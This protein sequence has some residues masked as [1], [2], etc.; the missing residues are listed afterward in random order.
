M[1]QVQ[2]PLQMN[3]KKTAD[4]ESFIGNESVVK[5]LKEFGSLP[6]FTYIWGKQ[7]SGKSHLIDA[8]NDS[9]VAQSKN[10]LILDAKMLSHDELLNVIP[11]GVESILIDDVGLCASNDAGEVGLFN[12]FN[13]CKSLDCKLVVTARIPARADQWLLPDLKSRLNS[14]LILHLEPLNH[15]KALLCLEQQFNVHGIPLDPAVMNYLRANQNTSFEYL[16]EL[17]LCLAAE[18]L[19]LKRKVT[20]PLVKKAIQ[21]N[22]E[23]VC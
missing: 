17:F 9:L 18:S 11:A 19:K 22:K 16:Y 5:S 10:V 6:G 13:R 15:E 3:A 7:Y 1:T 14:G 8:M 12:L 23:S 21:E 4:F 20:V 2:L